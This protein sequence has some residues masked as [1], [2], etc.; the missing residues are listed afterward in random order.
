MI[1]GENT[2][3]RTSISIVYC[4]KWPCLLRENIGVPEQALGWF[5]LGLGLVVKDEPFE[6]SCITVFSR[7]S[8]HSRVSAQVLIFVTQMARKVPTPG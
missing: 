4:S 5:P 3:I 6:F 7:A 2:C 8:A 1:L